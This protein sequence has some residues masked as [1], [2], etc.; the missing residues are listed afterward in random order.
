MF[1]LTDKRAL[2]VGIAN[3]HSI[4]WGVAQ[5][6]HRS[7]AEVAITYLNEKA[8]VHVRPLAQSIGAPI[9]MPLDVSHDEHEGPL[10]TRIAEVWGRL[11][12]V[13]HSIAFAPSD[14]LHGRVTDSSARGFAQAMDVSVHSFIR[15]VRRAE[16]LM[17]KGGACFTMSFYGAE[18]VVSTYSVM[19]PVKAALEA[20]TRELAS[21]LGPKNI[22]VNALSPGPMATRA[23]SGIKHFDEMLSEA[24]ARAPMRRLA[25]IEDVGA[26]AAFLAS[27]QARNITGSVLHIDAGYHIMG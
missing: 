10:F 7:G 18:K 12:V 21:E 19:G 16:P 13:V 23:A 11:D 6:L 5:A 9:V 1:E 4:A 22:T 27:D 25:T 24:T 8:E 3:E 26:A 17:T 20:V 2:V 15:L 14:D